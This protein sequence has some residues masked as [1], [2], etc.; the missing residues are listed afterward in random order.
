LTHGK[1][2]SYS[3]GTTFAELKLA[4]RPASPEAFLEALDK[5]VSFPLSSS[6]IP[7][8]ANGEELF[9]AILAYKEKFLFVFHFLADDNADN[10]PGIHN[11]EGGLIRL[12]AKKIPHD[13]GK[14]TAKRIL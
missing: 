3:R 7:S 13:Y 12:F 5:N 14:N 6:W 1:F 10:V 4:L 9:D 11:R 2:H 8:R